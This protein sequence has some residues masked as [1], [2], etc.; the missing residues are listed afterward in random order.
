M[1]VLHIVGGMNVGGTETMLMNIYRNIDREKYEFHFVSYYNKK[2]FYDDEIKKLGGKIIHMNF[3]HRFGAISSFFQLRKLIKENNYEIVHT[4]TL[5]NCGIGVLA[6]YLGGAKVRI[7]HAHTVFEKEDSALKKIYMYMMK[8][9]IRIYSNNFLACSEKAG[10]FLFGKD[11]LKKE[12]YSFLPNYV[13]YKKYMNKL[14]REN[15]RYELGIE[16][17]EIVL[18]HV[19]RLIPLKNHIFI[20]D[21]I[22]LMK[23]KGKKVKAIFVGDGDQRENI[24]KKIK[25]YSL[26]KNIIITGMVTNPEKY[27]KAMDIF[28]LPSIYE[29]FGLVLLE[30]QASNLSCLTSEN[31]QDE[32]DLELG[33]VTKMRLDDGIESW[34]NKIMEI[35]KNKKIISKD[36]LERAFLD[37]EYDLDCILKKIESIY[38]SK[39]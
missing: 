28:L 18:G 35:L 17:D 23:E 38:G 9:L 4:H 26:E 15:V 24:E 39:K 13:D 16:K 12:N 27:M 3:S 14:S 11:I 34:S 8:K 6:A 37:K 20:L 29:G 2:G 1:K 10:I 25:E 30:A 36:K 7:S 21:I 33:L 32:I 19:G 5:F 31:I 22:K